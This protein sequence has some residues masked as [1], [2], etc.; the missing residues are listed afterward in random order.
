MANLKSGTILVNKNYI[1]FSIPSYQVEPGKEFIYV[2]E[3]KG[4]YLVEFKDRSFMPEYG[5]GGC[6]LAV[7]PSDMVIKGN[8]QK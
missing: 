5:Y 3:Y 4:S 8:Q 2:G 7:R 1:R 6:V